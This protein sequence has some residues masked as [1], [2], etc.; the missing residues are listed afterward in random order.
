MLKSNLLNVQVAR[1][2]LFQ[3]SSS[4]DSIEEATR[5]ATEILKGET[6]D[7]ESICPNV[8]VGDL[9]VVIGIDLNQLIITMT[10]EFNITTK[11]S[12]E[13]LEY[14][15]SLI[16]NMDDGLVA[17]DA[18]VVEAE[19]W[20]WTIPAT[21]FSVTTL[22]VVST[23]GVIYAWRGK[24]GQKMQ[25]VMS[26]VVLPLLMATTVACWIMVLMSSFGTMVGSDVCTSSTS[27]GSPDETIQQILGILNLNPNTTGFKAVQAYTNVRSSPAVS[28]SIV[29]LD[30]T[31]HDQVSFPIVT[32]MPRT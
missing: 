7:V 14:V 11:K 17:Y 3:V 12:E 26:Y 10:D 31:S 23:L 16:Q 19:G 21:L 18:S 2:I 25:N 15:R 9:E 20:L 29:F 22:T 8:N 13:S 5:N 30:R 24:S 6:L 28:I 27:T 1:E 32:A 4:V